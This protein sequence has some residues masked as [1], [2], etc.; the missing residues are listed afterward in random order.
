MFSVTLSM[1]F[2]SFV[3]VGHNIQTWDMKRQTTRRS[4]KCPRSERTIAQTQDC[5][6]SYLS[7]SHISQP[8]NADA[9]K[10]FPHCIPSHWEPHFSLWW[11]FL[12][13]TRKC[14]LQT[15]ERCFCVPPRDGL[16]TTSCTWDAFCSPLLQTASLWPRLSSLCLYKTSCTKA[17]PQLRP[18]KHGYKTSYK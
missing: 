9:S 15:A 17:L 8:S 11:G 13:C 5:A 16:R 7:L 3:T 4:R 6:Q 10:R 1:S 14:L 18:Q 2:I 12:G